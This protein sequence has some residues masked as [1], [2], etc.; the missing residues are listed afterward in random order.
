MT[1]WIAACDARPRTVTPT[2]G[3]LRILVPCLG[4]ALVLVVLVDALIPS[5]W[6]PTTGPSP[7]P[8]SASPGA[9]SLA[10]PA[11]SPGLGAPGR[12]RRAP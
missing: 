6:S 11:S 1:A 5:C 3:R 12:G 2:D 9:V 10:W 7:A 4:A 8:S